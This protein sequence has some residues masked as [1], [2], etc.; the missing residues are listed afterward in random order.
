MHIA[1]RGGVV[2]ALGDRFD[3][4]LR[5]A[6]WRRSGGSWTALSDLS[7]PLLS[8]SGKFVDL[9]TSAE[10]FVALGWAQ[11]ST[12]TGTPIF[13]SR[14]G[15]TWVVEAT[16]PVAAGERFV[17]TGVTAV[18]GRLFVTG[19]SVVGG[20]TE[21][22]ILVWDRGE[23]TK[24][25]PR[26]SGMAGSGETQVATVAYRQVG[27][28]AGGVAKRGDLEVPAAWVSSDG[29]TWQRLPDS[30]VPTPAGGGAIHKIVA[31]GN[32]FV[33]AGN[34]RSGPLLWT[35]SDGRRWAAVDAPKKR[36]QAA[37]ANA[38]VAATP[39]TTVL[40]LSGEGIA[41]AYRRGAS[42]SWSVIDKPPAFPGATGGNAELHGVAASPTKLVAIGQDARGKPLVLTSGNTRSWTRAPLADPRARLVAVSHGRGRFA[43]AG[44]RLV[45]GRARVALWISK[46]GRRWRRLGGTAVSPLGAF[47]D[48]EADGK[49]FSIAA[50]EG[51]ARGVQV[52]AWSS[53]GRTAVASRI[54]GPGA[55]RA[56]CVGPNGA[57]VVAVR[58][59][60]ARAQIVAWHRTPTG[61]WSLEPEVV[62]N[63][64]IA[65][66]C[67][68]GPSGTLVVGRGTTDSTAATWRRAGP[69]APWGRTVLAV[70]SPPSGLLA[71]GR[72]GDGF[73]TTGE[74]GARGQVDL[75]AWSIRRN[76]MAAMGG[77]VFAEPGYQ[78]GLGIARFGERIVIVGR[79]GAGS[80]AIWVGPGPLAGVPGGNPIG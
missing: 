65:E 29:I 33:A 1:R 7:S 48:I 73:L 26:A 28:V 15:T 80:G 23:W 21:G 61:R 2:V 63:A 79:R 35:S 9:T 50:M 6:A 5:P 22:R 13:A 77:P 58:G 51:T 34:S 59:D 66:G 38:H 17:P 39:T 8:F 70:T 45:D 42:G 41:D 16:V 40:S 19:G 55:A 71:V 43:I 57:T 49:R 72:D 54:L 76:S 44:W 25:D 64:A 78:A 60:G 74:T 52:S 32:R 75:A 62:A 20:A 18:G 11:S 56:I 27:F 69:G 36:Y 10:G 53:D 12:G 14:D 47:V 31:A 4:V 37:W 3:G 24:I 30:A 68:D 46:D 67:A